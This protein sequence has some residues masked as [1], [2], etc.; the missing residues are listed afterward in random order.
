M[1][2]LRSKTLRYLLIIMGWCALAGCHYQFGRGELSQRYATISVP[3]A[4]GDQ[5]GDL[6][7]EVIK[8]LSTSGAFR[9]VNTGGD[10]ILK[11]KLFELRDENIDFRYDRKKRGKLR[12]AIIP[13]ETR[14]TVAAEVLVIEAGTGQALRGP[15]QIT[16]STEF[17]HTYYY[18]RDEINVF[19]LGQ[20]TDIDAAQDAAM[21]PL[22][23]QLAARI[24]D[25]IINS[26]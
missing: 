7:T 10:L 15:T 18:T 23:R 2:L 25:Y 1:L 3:Y 24:V 12:H 26:W 22:H 4:E 8:Q 6:T 21:Y 14:L 20:L 13:T 5:K 16:A 11:I 17:D 19:S 9:Y